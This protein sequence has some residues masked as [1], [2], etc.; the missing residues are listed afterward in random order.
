MKLHVTTYC[1]PG[2]PDHESHDRVAVTRFDDGSVLCVLSDGVGSG[3]DPARC[4]ERV[5]KLVS[6][7]FAARPTQWPVQKV[8]RQLVG[9]IN[10]SLYKE[11]AFIDEAP[12]MQATLSVVALVENRV[13]GLNVGD[14]PIYRLKRAKLEVLSQ[15]HSRQS[16]DGNSTLLQAMGMGP[17]LQPHQFEY[18][19]ST[20]DIFLLSSDGVANLFGNDETVEVALLTA[21]TART[22]V[23]S[24]LEK[25]KDS[26]TDD[27]SAILISV[28]ELGPGKST[29]ET[30]SPFPYPKVGM[31]V[32]GYNLT[33][34]LAD[35][36]RVWLAENS[37]DRVVIKFIPQ[38]AETD[39][40]GTIANRFSREIWNASRIVGPE[41]ITAF[42]PQ[43]GAHY[44]LMEYIEAPTLST[45]LKSRKLT[46]DEVILLGGF[47]AIAT[48]KLL[49]HELIHGDIKPENVLVIGHGTEVKFKLLDLGIA[50]PVFTAAGNSGTATYLAPERFTGSV[51]TE[52]TELFSIGV[53][54]FEAL[55]QRAP[56]GSIERFQKPEFGSLSAPRPSKYN[57]NVPAWLDAVVSKCLAIRPSNRFQH[58]SELLFAFENP[59]K[60]PIDLGFSGPLLETNPLLFYKLG[61]FLFL[62]I[63]LLLGVTLILCQHPHQ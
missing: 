41:F 21:A 56:F 43:S 54:L 44:Y 19:L 61:F 25:S 17:D 4:A 9:Q 32:E 5:V 7:G 15:T 50:C 6:D 26:K 27:L 46:V 14:S 23:L 47:L 22:V 33:R 35:S 36:G 49:S 8:L 42:K 51:V 20:G 10:E 58:Y 2:T 24:A 60:A 62:A 53:T 40:S 48:Q 3:R 37:L 1:Q 16:R 28:Q 38:E 31:I 59:D 30:P 45:L 12:S 13:H 18:P 63:S 57:V 39:D 34:S 52:R 29:D 11:G 55:T